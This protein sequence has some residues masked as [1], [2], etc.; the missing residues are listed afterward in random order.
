MTAQAGV[1]YARSG[2]LGIAYHAY[3]EGSVNLVIVPRFISNLHLIWDIR[4]FGVDASAVGY[5][6]PLFGVR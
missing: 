3:G 6:R 2:E 1:R 4:A 5:L